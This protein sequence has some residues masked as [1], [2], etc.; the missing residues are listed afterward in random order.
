MRNI[1]L[2]AI[3]ASAMLF[4]IPVKAQE[5][6]EEKK[7]VIKDIPTTSV[8]DQYRAGTC[9][10]YSG[11]SLL[12]TELIRMGKGEYDLSEMFIVRNAYQDK[13]EKYVRLHGNG[14]FGA[15]GSF[16]DV[17]YVFEN[18]GILTEDQYKGYREQKQRAFYCLAKSI[19]RYS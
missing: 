13:A 9:W 18:Y 4:V 8:K 6:K 17:L 2:F 3:L 14:N 16:Y 5:D 10:S 1:S 19:R 15:G 11:L 7:E 12:E